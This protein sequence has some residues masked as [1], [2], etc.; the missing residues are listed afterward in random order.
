[1]EQRCLV[2]ENEDRQ[3]MERSLLSEVERLQH[4]VERARQGAEMSAQCA[5][6]LKREVSG[7]NE[8]N[9]MSY[10]FVVVVVTMAILRLQLWKLQ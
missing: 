8:I 4:E 5:D 6:N 3:S 9:E 7:T 10:V 2:R 1:M